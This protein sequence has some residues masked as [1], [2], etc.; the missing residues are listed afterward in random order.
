MAM[1]DATPSSAQPAQ[2]V[3]REA[4]HERIAE[5]FTRDSAVFGRDLAPYRGHAQR[6]AA[7]G[8]SQRLRQLAGQLQPLVV[9]LLA[10]GLQQLM[11]LPQP[12]TQRIRTDV[13]PQP[14]L[15]L[16]A[17]QQLVEIESGSSDRQGLDRIAG[18]IA[19]RLRDL[20]GQVQLVGD[21]LFVTNPERLQRGIDS[22][23]ANALLVKVNQIASPSPR[24]SKEIIETT[25]KPIRIS[26]P[27]RAKRM[28]LRRSRTTLRA[29][30]T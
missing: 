21:D 1:T 3:L 15:L 10:H 13:K 6:V 30:S 2:A 19:Q 26:N 28:R 8:A 5:L 12:L 24:F 7:A 9:G 20:G 25:C 22:G 29:S 11:P 27:T 16:D 4:V 17:L 14:H 18:V 23:T